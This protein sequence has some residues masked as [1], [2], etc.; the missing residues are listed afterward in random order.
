MNFIKKM[1]L[2]VSLLGMA[3][4]AQAQ[5]A[6]DLVIQGKKAKII[7]LTSL[8]GMQNGTL[9]RNEKYLFGFVG[10]QGEYV[11]FIYEIATGKV[12]T[13]E[14]FGIVEVKDFDNFVTTSHIVRDGQKIEFKTQDLKVEASYATADLNVISCDTKIDGL[15][16][17]V[18][19]DG[20]GNIIDTMPHAQEGLTPGYGSY[21][22]DMS[23]DGSVMAGRSSLLDAHTN[24]TPA[25][26][27][28]NARKTVATIDGEDFM[29]GTLYGISQNGTI[30]TGEIMDKPYWVAYD[31]TTQNY[32]LHEIP[33]FPGYGIGW[34]KQ[35]R[36]NNNVVMGVDQVSG[37][38]VYERQSWLYYI[39]EDRKVSL[40]D[41]LNYLYGLDV[42]EDE[43]PLFTPL[44]MSEDGRIITGYTINFVWFPYIIL[45]EDEQIHP[46]V[47]N[48]LVRQLYRTANVQIQWDEPMA[49]DYTLQGYKIYRDSTLLAT[50]PVGQTTYTDQSVAEGVHNY[51]VQAIYTDGEG[52]DYSP[53]KKIHVTE[54]GGCLPVKDLTSEVIYN[55]TV[56]LSWGLPSADISQNMAAPVNIQREEASRIS[57]AKGKNV[58]APKYVG[59]QQF[60]YVSMMNMQ[61]TVAGSAV[62]VG[63]Y[64]YVGYFNS[65][66]IQI[67]N[68]LTGSL[69]ASVEVNGLVG[70]YDMAYHNNM[71]Y[72]V[73]N[74]N[75][76]RVFELAISEDNP[77]DIT[78]SNVWQAKTKLT[79]ISYLEGLN[80]GKDMILTGNWD[81]L[82]FYNP[83]P[84]DE[85]DLVSGFADRFDLKDL[86]VSGSVYYNGRLYLANQNDGNSSLIEVFDWESGEHL[87]TSNLINFPI[88][89]STVSYPQ[90]SALISGINQ[91]TLEDGTVV[92]D[93]M[94]QPLTTHNHLVTIEIESSPDVA[95]YNVW[96]N[97]EK[98]NEELIKARH[99]SEKVFIPGD[100]TYTIEYVAE[101]GCTSKSDD[102]AKETITI[103]PTGECAAPQRVAVYESNETACLTWE[104]PAETDGFVGFNVYR[105]GE[106]LIEE[107]IDLKF[108]DTEIEKAKKYVYTVEAFYDNSCVASDSVDLVPT[109]EGT[110]E[111]PS[112]VTCTQKK[113]A[114]GTDVTTTWDLPYFETPLALGYCS[115]PVGAVTLPGSNVLYALVG[116]DSADLAKYKDLYV[117]GVEFVVGTDQLT[118]NAIVY[119]NGMLRQSES[120]GRIRAQEWNRVYLKKPVS[121]AQGMIDV[122]Y[123]VQF[124]AEELGE[125]GV[126][127]YD[128]GPAKA[129]YSDQVSPDG[130]NIYSLKASGVDANL[131]INALV[132]RRRDMEEA[133]KMPEAQAQEY[134][135]KKAV[136]LSS[137]ELTEPSPLNGVKT[138][139]ESYSLK[140]FNVYRD[141]KKLNESVLRDFSYVDEGMKAGEYFYEVSAIYADEEVRSDEVYVEIRDVANDQQ[142]AVCPVSFQP[143]PVQDMLYIKGE[144]ASLSLIDMTGRVVLSDVRNVQSLP[145]AN[146]QSGIYFVKVTTEN[147]QVYITKIV[148]K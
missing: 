107:L 7:Y 37:P 74:D 76:K 11:G 33:L 2:A 146:F 128:F 134:L 130:V 77:F 43:Y 6:S 120:A 23:G 31:K 114:N 9:S 100:Y 73:C 137:V 88:V 95:G 61:S 135:I 125:S 34:G 113:G 103:N 39:D 111:A 22:F 42:D 108:F 5:D 60:D 96:R 32:V 20:Q 85:N 54:V 17:S 10:D 145:M 72:C 63:D 121:M 123:V 127:A 101:N 80:D 141:G 86:I 124:N 115:V 55:R 50:L 38:Q 16:V 90:Y 53:V 102:Y 8:P 138:T 105:N 29:D 47:R 19:L 15:Y 41:Y 27:D 24:F 48:V 21:V 46:L 92:L 25:I 35:V 87:F 64:L 78:L 122:G 57:F 109:F 67:Y 106:M 18:L 119:V 71:L 98:V 14:E 140:G 4:I 139:S 117:V 83:N 99:Y 12:E 69:A 40:H 132:V 44:S 1:M 126:L 136:N 116:W 65:N 84:E 70:V 131:C 59:E 133:A 89:A 68:V 36:M 26:W 79:H 91:G 62:R 112:A 13:Y 28:R 148:K 45:L 30:A 143:N 58:S 110:A 129:G 93:A 3:C 147:G 94:I 144:Y 56:N 52:S 118:A 104:V 142:D 97:G 81:G 49:G 75:L 51:Q 66:L 82:L